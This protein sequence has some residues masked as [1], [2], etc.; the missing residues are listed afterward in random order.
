MANAQ[1][2]CEVLVTHGTF[3]PGVYTFDI[4]PMYGMWGKH[5]QLVQMS[6]YTWKETE[7]GVFWMK[8]RYPGGGK[9]PSKLTDEELKDFVWIKLKAK[10][11]A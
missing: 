10:E 11:F 6:H 4:D 9:I 5:S 1:Y 2:Y 3:S 8:N 7:H